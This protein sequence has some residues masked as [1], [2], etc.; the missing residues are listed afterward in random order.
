MPKCNKWRLLKV[1]M[2]NLNSEIL[3]LL[4]KNPR[5][6]AGEVAQPVNKHKD[7]SLNPKLI[8]KG[9]KK[10]GMVAMLLIPMLGSKNRQ[11]SEAE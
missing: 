10:L 5:V 8:P 1:I 4:Y 9:K 11:I 2:W 3:G 6:G 7:L